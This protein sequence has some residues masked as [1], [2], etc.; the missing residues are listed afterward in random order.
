MAGTTDRSS[1][2]FAVSV[3]PGDH[4]CAFY[5]GR[6]ERDDVVLDDLRAELQAG[7]TCVGILDSEEPAALVDGLDHGIDARP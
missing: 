4:L 6:Q 3:E 7:H 2:P 5:L 1:G